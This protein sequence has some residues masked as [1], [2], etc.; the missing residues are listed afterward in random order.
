MAGEHRTEL[1]GDEVIAKQEARLKA[2]LMK[3]LREHL[4]GAVTLRHEDRF[5]SGIPDISVTWHGRTTWW[6]CKHATPS[7]VSQGIQELTL[8]RLA[9]AGHARYIVWQERRGVR[10]TMIVHPNRLRDLETETTCPGFD[11]SWLV[12]QIRL[13]HLQNGA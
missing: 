13:A 10:R 4:L 3:E 1:G 5:T 2:T 6:E 7:L 11:M 12:E 9:A 8:L